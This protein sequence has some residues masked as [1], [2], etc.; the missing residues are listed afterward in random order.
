MI[1]SPVHSG[2]W[3]R[4]DDH[5]QDV[6]VVVIHIHRLNIAPF[7]TRGVT[8]GNAVSPVSSGIRNDITD[9]GS[10]N[11]TAIIESI[12]IS[13]IVCRINTP[14]IDIPIDCV[15]CSRYHHQNQRCNCKYRCAAHTFFHALHLFH[16]FMPSYFA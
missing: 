5:D 1:I 7:R 11:Q 14:V 12:G 10:R 13:R 9:T 8:A 2:L 15:C 3:H 16:I 4:C 6:C